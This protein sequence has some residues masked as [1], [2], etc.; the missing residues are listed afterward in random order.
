[1]WVV[2]L[3]LC[4]VTLACATPYRNACS[5]WMCQKHTDVKDEQDTK[6]RDHATNDDLEDLLQA[7][8]PKLYPEARFEPNQQVSQ[9]DDMDQESLPWY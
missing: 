8:F 3:L 6:V 9:Q 5:N 7:I 2:Y 1:M 4:A